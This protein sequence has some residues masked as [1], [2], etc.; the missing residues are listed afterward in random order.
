MSF[1]PG[2]PKKE[3]ERSWFVITLQGDSAAGVNQP[4]AG[5]RCVRNPAGVS[6]VFQVLPLGYRCFTEG[7]CRADSFK[8][9][10]LSAFLLW[11]FC[12]H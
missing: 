6:E 11:L 7:V 3:A 9:K 12:R 2:K 1:V 8:W 5:G 10:E 4:G